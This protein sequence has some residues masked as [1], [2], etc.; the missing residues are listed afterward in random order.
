MKNQNKQ[1]KLS[2]KSV[3]LFFTLL[4][5][6]TQMSAQK[7]NVDKSSSIGVDQLPE[8]VV[9]TSED[10]K[11][12]GGMNITIQSKK[13]DYKDALDDLESL[14]QSSKKLQIRTQTDLL[15]AMFEL[16]F[17]FI[18]AYNASSTAIGAGAGN[19]VTVNGTIE[20][21]R[22]NMVFKKRKDL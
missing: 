12:L 16:G 21:F 15:N 20:K 7:L 19:D 9:I 8:Y 22:V 4:L 18:N 6:V 2:K 5:S 17:E 1:M 11:L 13:S 10:T 14:L 3:V